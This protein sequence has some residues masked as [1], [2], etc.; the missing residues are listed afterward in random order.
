MRL[1]LLYYFLP[2]SLTVRAVEGG[3]GGCD[4]GSHQS[5]RSRMVRRL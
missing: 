1:L 2:S 5:W 3:E 4:G